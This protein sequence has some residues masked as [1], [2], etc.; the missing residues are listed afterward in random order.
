M[1][2]REPSRFLR[3]YLSAMGSVLPQWV[4]AV[5]LG[6]PMA[7]MCRFRDGQGNARA[8]SLPLA[9]LTGE[10]PPARAPTRR[11]T[12]AVVP[13]HL[14]LTRRVSLPRKA[15]RRMQQIGALDLLQKTPFQAPEIIWTIGPVRRDKEQIYMTQVIALQSDLTKWRARMQA[16]NHPLRRLYATVEGQDVLIADYSKELRGSGRFW[17]TLNAAGALIACLCAL[18]L[19]ALPGLQAD[20][21][22][23]TLTPEIMRLQAEALRLREQVDHLQTDQDRQQGLLTGIT[24][25]PRFLDALAAATTA[26]PDQVWVSQ[27]VF[28]PEGAR[29]FVQV[30]GSAVDLLYTI[31][32]Q[33]HLPNTLMQG[34]V[35]RTPSG[36]EEVWLRHDPVPRP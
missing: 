1:S 21:K 32:D 12:D 35:D 23:A 30:D 29:M 10:A 22:L 5:L 33:G 14:V 20:E 18:Y 6:H 8:G 36:A 28:D 17:P 3:W 31:A 7:R 15:A 16:A 34:E 24:T 13:G 25:A 27:Y 19:W 4:K 11:V 26:L 2:N 9:L